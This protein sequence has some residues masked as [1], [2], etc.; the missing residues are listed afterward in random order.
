MR[1][2]APSQ[3]ACECNGTHVPCLAD[4]LREPDHEDDISPVARVVDQPLL[5]M[6]SRI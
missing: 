5:C 1:K 3:L 4:V 6:A 2:G